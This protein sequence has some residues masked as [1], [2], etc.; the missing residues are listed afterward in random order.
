MLNLLLILPFY[1]LIAITVFFSH[2]AD[3]AVVQ[4]S[5]ED[6]IAIFVWV[7]NESGG[8]KAQE[9]AKAHCASYNKIAKFRS[10]DKNVYTYDCVVY[11][12]PSKTDQLKELEIEARLLEL[13]ATALR[14][15]RDHAN[16][17][18]SRVSNI[19]EVTTIDISGEISAELKG[20]IKN[21]ADLKA[22]A[23][24]QYH[25]EQSSGVPKQE[26]RVAFKDSNECRLEVLKQLK[27]L[28]PD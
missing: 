13:K 1:A 28:L 10:L 6:H 27:S 4:S 3:A 8:R 24:G 20:V 14:M 12:D 2:N 19:S 26:L 15:I 25:S 23:D 11:Q 5:G 9:E 18:C 7:A 16:D 22:G 17:T 21:I